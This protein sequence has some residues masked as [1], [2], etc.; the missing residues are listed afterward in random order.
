MSQNNE[1][2]FD[3][4]EELYGYGLAWLDALEKGVQERDQEIESLKEKLAARER[5]IAQIRA[6]LGQGEN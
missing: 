2:D 4:L 3:D 1:T 5:Q 6:A